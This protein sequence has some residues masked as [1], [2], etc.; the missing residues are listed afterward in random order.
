MAGRL[1]FARA[2]ARG[3]ATK[4]LTNQAAT[5]TVSAAMDDRALA[6]TASPAA[7]HVRKYTP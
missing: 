6:D 2:E 1:S 3:G 4:Q 5:S 7:A